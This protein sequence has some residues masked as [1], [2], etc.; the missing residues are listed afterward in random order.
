MA[1]ARRAIPGAR[2]CQALD[3]V[4]IQSAGARFDPNETFVAN[5]RTPRIDVKRTFRIAA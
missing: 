5:N 3:R 4:K 2:R 1:P